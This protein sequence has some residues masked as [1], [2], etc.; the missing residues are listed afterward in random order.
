MLEIKIVSLDYEDLAL[1]VRNPLLVSVVKIAEV[2]DADALFV[3]PSTFLDLG[4]QGRDR[5]LEIDEQIRLMDHGHHQVE[6]L[7]IGVEVTV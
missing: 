3:I 2:F 1:V 6:K 7:H 5:R 4:N